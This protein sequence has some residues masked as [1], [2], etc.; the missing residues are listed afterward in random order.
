MLYV[1]GSGTGTDPNVPIETFIRTSDDGGKNRG[2]I[3]NYDSLSRSAFLLGALQ[4]RK[5]E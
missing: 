3:Y 2:L 4:A 5:V 1:N